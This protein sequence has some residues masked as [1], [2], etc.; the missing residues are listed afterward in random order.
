MKSPRS[1]CSLLDLISNSS[2]N[3]PLVGSPCRKPT[4]LSTDGAQVHEEFGPWD[5]VSGHPPVIVSRVTAR[6][7][8]DT[9]Q[10][11]RNSK[12]T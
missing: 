8:S 6:P 2:W 11:L 9:G 1:N 12:S 7:D 4:S 10:Y 5:S 3:D